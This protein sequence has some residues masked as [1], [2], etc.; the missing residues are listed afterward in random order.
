MKVDPPFRPKI[1]SFR[2]TGNFDKIFTM[3][4]AEDTFD[5]SELSHSN[6][7]YSGFT[8][9]DDDSRVEDGRITDS[10]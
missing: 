10:S 3:E 1:K 6:N 9:R 7:V 8:Y 2:D 5:I 4:K